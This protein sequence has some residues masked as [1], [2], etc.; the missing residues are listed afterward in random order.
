MQEE[1]TIKDEY[2]P[3]PKLTLNYD[4]IALTR[5]GANSGMEFSKRLEGTYVFVSYAQTADTIPNTNLSAGYI[6][7]GE[8]ANWT[9]SVMQSPANNFAYKLKLVSPLDILAPGLEFTASFTSVIGNTPTD[10]IVDGVRLT[11]AKSA[12]S[13]GASYP[14]GG[15]ARVGIN[16]VFP[17]EGDNVTSFTLKVPF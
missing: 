13:A 1:L 15:R 2:L 11:T 10:M 12:A 3:V 14:I 5:A 8:R 9:I 7:E 6:I 17:D 16:S 4:A